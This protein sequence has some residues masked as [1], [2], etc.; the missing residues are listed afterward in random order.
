MAFRLPLFLAPAL[1]VPIHHAIRRRT[2]PD[3][4][5]PWALDAGLTIPFLLDT[6]GNAVGLYDSVDVTDDVLHF[7][8]WCFLMGGITDV[9]RIRRHP[10]RSRATGA[11]VADLARRHRGR[12][13]RDHRVGDRRIRGDEG[14][15]GQPVAHLRRHAVRP[16]A[17]LGR[18]RARR[19]ARHRAGGPTGALTRSR[20][21]WADASAEHPPS[22]AR[23][24]R[25]GRR[26]RGRSD[27]GRRRPGHR[28]RRR[29]VG[30]PGVHRRHDR[31]HLVHRRDV[32]HRHQRHC[33]HHGRHDRRGAGQHRCRDRP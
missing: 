18:R 30:R 16:R 9:D 31:R 10:R 8:N 21:P 2:D 22:D 12:R 5:Y 19:M 33:R 11:P 29:S 14:R 17:L 4:T 20:I 28:W 1:I 26:G 27:R 25:R 3:R 32:D 15:R 24:R 6:F 7:V 13:A 23:D